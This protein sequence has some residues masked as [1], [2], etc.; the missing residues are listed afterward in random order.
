YTFPASYLLD[1]DH[2]GLQDLIIAPN[3]AD[4]DGK[5]DFTHSSSVYK[6]VGTAEQYQFQKQKDNFLQDGMIEVGFSAAAVLHDVDNDGRT[7]MVIGNAGNPTEGRLVASLTYYKNT[8]TDVQPAFTLQTDDF[9][10]LSTAGLTNMKPGFADLTGD[11]V[12]DLYF[13]GT[14]S[15]GSGALYYVAAGNGGL[16]E[17]AIP[18]SIAVELGSADTPVLGA[19][20]DDEFADMVITRRSGRYDYYESSVVNGSVGLKLVQE[21]HARFT[22]KFEN[23]NLTPALFDIHHDGVNELIISNSKGQLS[24]IEDMLNHQTGLEGSKAL[25]IVNKNWD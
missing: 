11:G 18:I 14:T 2:D 21:N 17:N 12:K 7:D 19:L 24:I 1:T 25:N 8:G 23:R 4:N 5:N 9:L 20:N 3:L 22:A 15:D 6:N 13:S 10:N 16:P